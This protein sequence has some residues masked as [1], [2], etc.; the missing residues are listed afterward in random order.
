MKFENCFLKSFFFLE[1]A[2]VV[3]EELFPMLGQGYEGF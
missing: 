3:A 1:P 2:P